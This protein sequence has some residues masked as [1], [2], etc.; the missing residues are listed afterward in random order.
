MQSGTI[1]PEDVTPVGSRVS[2]GAIFAGAVTALA[3]YF[4]LT[5]LGAALGLSLNGWLHVQN[6]SGGAA[7]WAIA[8]ML[9]ALFIGGIVTSQ[10]TVGETKGEAVLYGIILWGV[11]VGAVVWLAASGVRIGFQAI[12]GSVTM[13]EPAVQN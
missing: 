9:I 4:L 8:S 13:L 10:C 11:L 2:W 12:L 6:V 5:L 7:L 3:L 1:H